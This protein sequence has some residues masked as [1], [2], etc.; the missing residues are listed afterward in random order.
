MKVKIT[1]RVFISLTEFYAISLALHPSLDE[2]TV[3][4]KEQRLIEGLQTLSY[5]ANALPLA[6]RKDWLANGYHD[7]H[8]EGFHFAY[9]IEVLQT[10]YESVVVVYD[11]CHDLLYHD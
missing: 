4:A 7:F 1:D 9:R 2:P 11:A 3:N 8:C 6:T 5:C 10:T